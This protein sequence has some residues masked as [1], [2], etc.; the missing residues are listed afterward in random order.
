[1]EATQKLKSAVGFAMK[2][3]KLKSGDFAVEKL[4]RAGGV[5]LVLLDERAS[6]N[7]RERYARLC[8]NGKTALL[9][10]PALG[11]SIGKPGRMTAAVTDENFVNMILRSAGEAG[12]DGD[13]T[14][15]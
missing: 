3:G 13:K 9:Y 1:M 7:T 8:E 2:A 5:R 12:M 4:V 15:G 14:R 6:E 11:E 10:V